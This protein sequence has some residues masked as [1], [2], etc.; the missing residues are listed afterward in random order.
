MENLVYL[1]AVPKGSLLYCSQK[2]Q[3]FLWDKYDLHR[4]ELPELHLTLEAISYKDQ[5]ELQSIR[6][7][8]RDLLANIAPFE[9]MA[10]G[11]SY[12]PCPYNCITIHIVKTKEL[13]EIYQQIHEGLEKKGFQVREFSSNEIVF[14]IS[15]A[16][17][18]GRQWSEEESRR[19]WKDVKD[20][21]IQN[22]SFVDEFQLWF[23][24]LTSDKKVIEKF[25]LKG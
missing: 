20:F 24:E 10:S 15:L 1:V 12:I 6:K 18:H 23:P 21:H 19:A 13:K 11:F 7:V 8:I 4:G 3:Q 17:I 2:I 14:H 22:S 16:G 9:M 25:W 5:E